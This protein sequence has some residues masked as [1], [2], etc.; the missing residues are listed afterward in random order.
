[1]SHNLDYLHRNKI[2]YRRYPIND[3]PTAKYQWGWYYENGTHEYYSLFHSK[4]LITSYRSLKWHLYVLLYLNQD[5]SESQFVE[6]AQY[7]ANKKNG[8]I[9]FAIDSSVLSNIVKEVLVFDL[10]TQPNNKLRKVIFKDSTG[11]TVTEKLK[12]TGSLIGRNKNASE[13]DIYE[14]MLYIHEQ[15]EKITIEKIS[16]ALCVTTRT[17]YRNMSETLKKEKDQLNEELQLRKLSKV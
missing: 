9:S 8:F 3:Q 12:I 1:M 17:I 6:L 4:S 13:S 11:L 2:I 15:G 14:I 10:D 7:I 16:K 5:L